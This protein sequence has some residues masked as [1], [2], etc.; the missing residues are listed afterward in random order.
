M[1]YEHMQTTVS[2]GSKTTANIA[3]VPLPP[4]YGASAFVILIICSNL[5]V[6]LLK[7]CLPVG[8]LPPEASGQASCGIL[9][10]QQHK[11]ATVACK[12]L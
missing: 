12:P 11:Y 1:T 3:F 5:A 2:Y 10:P 6:I 7:A 9:I 8:R 4:Q